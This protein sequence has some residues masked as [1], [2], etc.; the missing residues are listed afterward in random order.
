MALRGTERFVVV[1]HQYVI[2]AKEF[3]G[4]SGGKSRD[5]RPEFDRLL[6]E[7][8]CRK[9]DVVVAWSVGPAWGPKIKSIGG[10]GL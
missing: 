6:K 1:H 5:K 4:I 8:V 3:V 9:I 7:V 2:E 10:V